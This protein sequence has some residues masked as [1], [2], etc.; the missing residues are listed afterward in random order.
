[1][2]ATDNSFRVFIVD[3]Y[4]MIYRAYFAFI[5][6]PRING[7]GV[8][9][10]A[11]FG[12]VSSFV[13]L[14]LKSRPS[15]V[16]VAFDCHEPTFRHKLFPDYKANRDAQPEDIQKAVPFVVKFIEA[17]GVRCVS[18]PGYEAD[19]IVGS[20]ATSF[21]E[22]GAQVV[23]VT[24][25]KD[26]AQLVR[27]GVSMLRP[28]SGGDP[29]LLDVDGVCSHFG[30]S[31]PAQVIDMLG[32]WGDASDN[33]PGC[34]GVGEKRAKELLASY[35]SID[36]IYDNIDSLKGKLRDNLILHKDQVLLSRRLATI[37]T[38]APISVSLA[39]VA[40]SE[41]DWQ[42][43]DAIFAELE[44]HGMQD[45]IRK[46]LGREVPVVDVQ[47]S[48]FDFADAAVPPAPA[49][50]AT[51]DSTPH[52]YHCAYTHVDLD[53]LCAK[54]LVSKVV[55]FDTETEDVNA[56][57]TDIVGFSVALESGEA[58]YAPLPKDHDTAAA[59]L[60]HV[61]PAFASDASI[62]VAQNMK[63]DLMVLGRYGIKVAGPRFDTMIAHFLL[64][65]SRRHN[66]DD[67]AEELL[68][69]R[70]IHID[71]LIGRG[72]RQISMRHVN[73]DKVV[74]Y[75]AEDADVTLR[76]YQVLAPQIEAKPELSKLFHDVEMPLVQV[77][78]DMEMAGV[79]IDSDA[80]NDYSAHL[81]AAMD[82]SQRKIFDLAGCEFNISSPKQVGEVLFDKLK[83]DPDA[84]RTK[85]GG[86]ATSEDV[87][88]K[89]AHSSP[90]VAEI[91]NYRGLVKLQGTYADALPRLVNPLTG[92]LHTS[93]NQ[94]VVVTGRLSSSNPNLQNIPVRDDN[95]KRIRECFVASPGC[96]IVAA[97]YSQ[98]ELR[99]MAHFCQDENM[100]AAFRNGEDIHRATA[101]KI[102]NVSPDE[103][104]TDMRRR[105]KSANFGII[106]G[107]SA[108]G[109]AENLDIP[110]KEAKELIDGY[111]Q[112]FPGVREYMSKCIDRARQS[113]V[114]STLFGRIRELPDIVSRNSVVRGVAERNAINAP[115]QG[116]AADIIK[117]AMIAVH[118]ELVSRNLKARM[119]LQVHDELVLDV[120]TAEVDVV[121]SI[122]KEQMEGAVSL[123]IPLTVDV[124]VGDNWLQ[125]H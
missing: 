80:L 6:A 105:A 41:P 91:L 63:F 31:S 92:R 48:L 66:M 115:L 61:A 109:L 106:Y 93:F 94:T 87:L 35:G 46:A 82:E 107:I 79:R 65:P 40:F 70:T 15:H 56:V 99:L 50:L 1:M 118:R 88:L 7:N 97:D 33:I 19:D 125:A 96:K 64:H 18:L 24:P 112:N 117:L 49:S 77:L 53:E 62:K 114:V 5:R 8:N 12:F 116:T 102:F 85:S 45:R 44:I 67:M 72:S 11:I 98:V 51:L 104:T 28:H 69:Y 90:I 13:D 95:G 78:A 122:L 108:F 43:L 60:A 103:V 36:G 30:L 2:S 27:P 23:M 83:V 119:I 16:V 17:L 42:A 57:S 81:V 111:F 14:V 25:D 32:L 71:E 75:A 39:D 73:L 84:K 76:L 34:P 37:V 89:L 55:C 101:A 59:L 124:G 10:S 22:Q 121:S 4:A 38:D 120:P 20:L 21:A 68:A 74:D 100:L 52:S 58:W 47:P 29:E 123:S 113:G 86:Y 54:M 9:T 3:A 26:Y 110:R